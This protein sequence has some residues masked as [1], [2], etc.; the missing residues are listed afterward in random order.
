[1]PAASLDVP[2]L[3]RLL[4]PAL[5][6]VVGLGTLSTAVSHVSAQEVDFANNIQTVLSRR[7]YACH[8]PDQ[9]EG[10]LRFDQRETLLVKADTGEIPVVPGDPA[11]SELIRRITSEDESER[12][13]PEGKPLTYE[14]VRAF[15][16]WIADGAKYEQHWAFQPVQSHKPPA[17][18]NSE[19]ARAPMD[20][21]V[22]AKLE[23]AKLTPVAQASP[24]KLIRRVY[25]DITGLPPSPERV[26][27]LASGWSEESYERLVDSL[28][29][30]SAFGERWARNWLDVVRYAET[31]SFERDGPKPNAYK[32]RDYVI[33]AM[34]SDKPYDQ[35][36][37]EQIAGDELDEVTDESLTA[38]GYYRLG[39]W[40][41]EPAD[42]KL[43][44]FD[45]Y[46]DLILTTGQGILGLTFN[47]A[48]CH[49]HK[50]D[51]I[52]QKDYYSLVAL[53]RDVTPY[54]TRGNQQG[55]NQVDLDPEL[56]KLHEEYERTKR[57]LE[58]K[59]RRFEQQA[60]KKM[61]AEDQRA[62]EGP[63]RAK[64]LAEKLE[65]YTK[66]EKYKEYAKQKAELESVRKKLAALPP[67]E[68]VLGLARLE[69]RP[70]ETKVLGRGSPL[71]EGEVVPPAF[72]KLLGGGVPEI[73]VAPEGA[74]SA[75]RRRVFAEWL[76]SKQ[77]WMTARVMA[78]RVWLHYFGRGIVRSPNNFGLMGDAP[79]HP[80]LVDHLATYLMDNNWHLKSL[81]RYI[82]LSS[83]YRLG[84]DDNPR[85]SAQDPANN[86]FWRQNL[87]RLSAE[88]VRDGVLAVTGQL[89]EQKFGASMYPTLSREVLASQSRPG[90]GWGRSSDADQ[91][92][93]SIYIHVKRSL[94]VPMLTA[95]DFPET[96]I[97]CEARFLTTQPAQALTMLNS[98]WMQQQ[99]D[100]LLARVRQ[101]VGEGLEAQAQRIL[102]LCLSREPD[103]ADV[104][105]LVQLTEKLKS[106][107]K[108]DDNKARQAMCLVALNLNQFLYLD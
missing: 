56:A 59:T 62:T 22:L 45:G 6:S 103:Q 107:H 17:V 5:A 51:P 30:D 16:A 68:R 50:I 7:C 71:A 53:L 55:N 91:S 72:P 13:P 80:E 19:W 89:N 41:D 1:M 23:S 86:L 31:N 36:I 4:Y 60:I 11:K 95:F 93:R 76:T 3:R 87:R 37:R 102:T 27:E 101:E 82:L 54:G 78:N 52:S 64:T 38:T 61:E 32:Y 2:S 65:Q 8:G 44:L 24:E 94:P 33:H 75:G 20:H 77:N 98:D 108:L 97:S 88:Q 67:R 100:K 105:E 92:R 28:L 42:P 58:G 49:D 73:P 34:N 96:D 106:K 84:T 70:P 39:L 57:D 69:A 85:A 46:D 63:E 79:T 15:K 104:M 12:M 25:I 43:A 47:C 40:D 66:P 83:T 81:H 74:K 26:T 9:Q 90:A 14:E 35:F 29:A 21:F 10:S 99:A 48:R 18:K